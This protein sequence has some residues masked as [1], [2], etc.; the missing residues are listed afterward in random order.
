MT[1]TRI[2]TAAALATVLLYGCASGGRPAPAAAAAVE[3]L[4][5][6][7]TERVVTAPVAKV[8]LDDIV[9]MAKAGQS[10][11]AIVNRIRAS[12][13]RIHLKAGDVVSLHERGVPLATIDQIIELDRN[14]LQADLAV[15]LIERDRTHAEEMKRLERQCNAACG[16]PYAGPGYWPGYGGPGVY[17]WF[18]R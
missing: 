9:A 10:G 4:P 6:P 8:T 11:E 17:W 18:G 15:Q 14:A 16:P 7:G 3:R 2:I 12:G 13:S 1:T 5:A